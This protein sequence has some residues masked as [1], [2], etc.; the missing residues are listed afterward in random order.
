MN[1]ILNGLESWFSQRPLWLQDAARR[2]VEKGVL[3]GAD[4]ADLITLCKQEAGVSVP[5]RL[6]RRARGIPPGSLQIQES[7]VTLRLEEISHVQG[8]NALAPRQPL[9][10]GEGPLTIIYGGTGSGKSG[11][12]RILKHACGAKNPGM[13]Y[14]NVFA[15]EEQDQWCTFTVKMDGELQEL[16]WFPD[17]GILDPIRFIEIYD[18]DCARIYLTEENEVAYEPWVL[19]LFTELTDVCIR[20]GKTL[21]EEIERSSP[22]IPP[23]PAQY[24]ETETGQWYTGLNHRTRQSDID[25]RC[26][27]NERLEKR[28]SGL[29]RR[30]LEP[31]PAEEA[32]RQR[33]SKGHVIALHDELE[34]MREQLSNEKCRR[35]LK[36]KREAGALR[37]AADE[38]AEKV[39]AN[40]PL[41]GVGSKSWR[42]L[43]EQARAYSETVAYKG[44]AF[45][46]ISE[47]ARCVLCHQLLRGKAGDRLQS[48][49]DFVKGNL[50][51]K[52]AAAEEE[53][54]NLT[55]EI[56]DIPAKKSL[57][58]RM[59]SAGLTADPERRE[60]SAFY[61]LIVKRKDSLLKAKS[62]AEIA[63][64][65]NQTLPGKLK[66]RAVNL[67]KRAREYDEAAKKENRPKLKE[68]A[69]ELEARQWLS[70]QKELIEEE[71]ERLKHV[72]NL[73]KA[74]KLT[75]PKA[76]SD[77]KSSL[78]GV[79]IS[80]AF[81]KR[82]RNELAGL[83]ASRLKVKLA[84]TRTEY[85]RVYH[86][87]M[88]KGC[89]R[90]IC[91]TDVLSDGEF[92]IVSLAAFLADVE[93]HSH[94]TP[95]VFDDPITSVDQDYEEATAKRL[96]DL[97]RSRQV[98]VF[99]HRLSLLALLEDAAAKAGIEPHVICLRQES[100]GIGEPG[101][102]PIFAKKPDRALNYILHERL[103][104]AR[105]VLKKDG[106]AE[107]DNIAKGICSDVRILIER[108]IENDLLADVVKR[109]RRSVETKGKI[110]RLANIKAEDCKLLDD[111][112]TLYS[113]YEHSQPEETP[114]SMPE[115]DKI[116][117]DLENI[118]S[119]LDDFKKR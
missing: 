99:T 97:C 26:L 44:I 84:K 76:L 60:V 48:F 67:E 3:K 56:E 93:G 42:L 53:A 98:I 39:F 90:D 51:E 96:I 72:N 31:D 73:E 108:I 119:W 25:S 5:V 71:V 74:R 94:V 29:N 15:E 11:Y 114:V 1:Q 7:P 40:A 10:F 20:I 110:H 45:P 13:L 54:E 52:A 107:Y 103:A 4:L 113:K 117:E 115:P 58:L 83:G 100:W 78:A 81:I 21:K 43:W 82:F 6:R 80:P 66:K 35:Y 32:K 87:I 92:R 30:L 118:L 49:E 101:D 77:K 24:R 59:D 116:E 104:K 27:W 70:E 9:Q 33:R 88:L 38:D 36:A 68:R 16:P 57:D 17:M 61:R 75:R 47:K 63:V 65:P 106:K 8:I 102:T 62:L 18:T 55:D 50:A 109:F 41:K 89:A 64:L 69:E 112:L 111:Y 19:S 95:F 12:V 34:G 46:N 79:L 105:K 91:T 22:A 85:G 2:L 23:L 28:L 37:K 86:Q 14:G